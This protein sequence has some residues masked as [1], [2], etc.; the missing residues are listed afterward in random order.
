MLFEHNF[1]FLR[2]C[3][4]LIFSNADSVLK[5]FLVQYKFTYVY[6]T[7]QCS[8]TSI[9]VHFYQC[10]GTLTNFVMDKMKKGRLAKRAKS[11]KEDV[12][13]IFSN[14]RSPANSAQPNVKVKQLPVTSLTTNGSD[15]QTKKDLLMII[16]DLPSSINLN[17][18]FTSEINKKILQVFGHSKLQNV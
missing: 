11:F 10:N 3:Q 18:H 6:T 9:T 8:V 12:I 16:E 7:T 5:F 2:M 13:D 15:R 14:L 4:I 17:Q 1:F